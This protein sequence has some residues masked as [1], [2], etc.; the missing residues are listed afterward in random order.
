MAQVIFSLFYNSRLLLQK[1]LFLSQL[2][3]LTF[4]TPTKGKVPQVGKPEKRRRRGGNA[5]FSFP[6]SFLLKRLRRWA[7]FPPFPPRRLFVSVPAMRSMSTTFARGCTGSSQSN[8]KTL[9][10]A[11]VAAVVDVVVVAAV[12]VA[13]AASRARTET[14]ERSRIFEELF[15]TTC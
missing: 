13:A 1:S 14:H 12:V 10:L 6:R 5:A 9:W 4:E 7:S 3:D 11:D 2:S 15:W 8:F